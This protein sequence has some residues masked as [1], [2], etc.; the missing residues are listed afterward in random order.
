MCDISKC[1]GLK[2]KEYKAH[3]C[4][5]RQGCLRYTS[6]P[7]PYRQSWLHSPFKENEC[8]FYIKIEK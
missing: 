1:D 4:P 3:I 5:F 7:N 8:E 2:I 6:K